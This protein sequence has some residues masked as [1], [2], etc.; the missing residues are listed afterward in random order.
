MIAKYYFQFYIFAIALHKEELFDVEIMAW[1]QMKS[2][3]RDNRVGFVKNIAQKYD[4]VVGFAEIGLD[5]E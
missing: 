4:C 5:L 2:G 1:D 3:L